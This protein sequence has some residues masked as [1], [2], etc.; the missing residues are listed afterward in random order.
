[1]YDAGERS[2]EIAELPESLSEAIHLFE[3]SDLMRKTL[4]DHVFEKFIAN[5][6]IEWDSYRQVVTGY[7]IQHS[8]P[9]L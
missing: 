3:K 2:S 4:G 9:R 1:M 5:K 8:L 6:T 7:E